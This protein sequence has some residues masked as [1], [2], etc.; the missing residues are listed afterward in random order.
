MMKNLTYNAALQDAGS[1]GTYSMSLTSAQQVRDR[2]VGT[3]AVG[4]G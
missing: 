3:I 4:G 1:A 2:F